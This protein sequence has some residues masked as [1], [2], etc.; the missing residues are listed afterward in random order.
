VF[1]EEV[2][3]SIFK[4]IE[5]LEAD[6][7]SGLKVGQAVEK[8]THILGRIAEVRWEVQ[9]LQQDSSL[10]KNDIMF[11]GGL[12]QSQESLEKSSVMYQH[13]FKLR[14]YN[15]NSLSRKRGKPDRGIHSVKTPIPGAET[16]P[17]EGIPA[18]T[19]VPAT[20]YAAAPAVAATVKS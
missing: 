14:D 10:A 15:L 13:V 3:S 1:I 8:V 9:N 16:A 2:Q 6:I 12:K 20:A 18:P 17:S 5:D 7:S 4:R 19:N 11:L